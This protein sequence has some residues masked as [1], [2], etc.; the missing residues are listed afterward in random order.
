M[1][2]NANDCTKTV[3]KSTENVPSSLKVVNNK[4]TSY[5]HTFNCSRSLKKHKSVHDFFDSNLQKNNTINGIKNNF[6]NRVDEIRHARSNAN[7]LRLFEKYSSYGHN[8]TINNHHHDHSNGVQNESGHILTN[9]K[10]KPKLTLNG[11]GEDLSNID[12]K[13]LVSTLRQILQD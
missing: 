12:V 2:K 8:N 3:T 6:E 5:Y 11:I 13:S 7:N 1:S 9:N 10:S 4:L